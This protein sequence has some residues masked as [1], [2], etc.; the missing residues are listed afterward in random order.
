[1]SDQRWVLKNP[2]TDKFVA[3]DRPSGGYPREVESVFEAELWRNLTDAEKYNAVMSWKDYDHPVYV[4]FVVTADIS[5]V[6]NL[7]T[8]VELE[9]LR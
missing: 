6:D 9:E 4:P 3:L 5:V 8:G 1:M 7:T 2:K